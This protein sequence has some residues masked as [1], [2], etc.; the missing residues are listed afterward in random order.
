MKIAE[1]LCRTNVAELGEFFWPGDIIARLWWSPVATDRW[2]TD[3]VSDLVAIQK[4]NRRSA[5]D[6]YSA[7]YEHIPL[8]N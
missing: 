6:N 3:V 1:E 8:V 2:P 4:I 7:R 5:H